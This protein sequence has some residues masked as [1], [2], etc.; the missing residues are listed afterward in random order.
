MI[1]YPK[2]YFNNILEIDNNFLDKNK[3]NFE[4]KGVVR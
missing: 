2:S 1:L 3:E 4:E